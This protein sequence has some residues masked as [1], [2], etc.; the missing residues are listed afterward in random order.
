MRFPEDPQQLTP[1]LL[2]EDFSLVQQ[3]L[4]LQSA[5]N[6]DC[7]NQRAAAGEIL[8]CVI[9]RFL[10]GAQVPAAIKVEDEE[11]NMR[12]RVRLFIGQELRERFGFE[13]LSP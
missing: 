12:N 8:L 5:I 6:L 3:E 13:Q 11:Q 10:S 2:E 9:Q 7:E 1:D 4:I